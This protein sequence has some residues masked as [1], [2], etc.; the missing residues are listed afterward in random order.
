[1]LPIVEDGRLRA[2]VTDR[3]LV[4]RAI[5]QQMDLTGTRAVECATEQPVTAQPDWD[6]DDA[7]EVMAREQVGRLPV[8]DDEGRLVGV[9]T[10]GS[11]VLR[12]GQDKR[13]LE[14][15]KEVSRRAAK[16]PEGRAAKHPEDRAATRHAV[17]RARG[18][19][20]RGSGRRRSAA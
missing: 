14:T 2:V 9:V 7:L 5:A 13:A 6:I 16:R 4:V 19:P 15:A 18:A 12:G 17:K 1:M 10:L 3:D 11:L 20:R 8:V